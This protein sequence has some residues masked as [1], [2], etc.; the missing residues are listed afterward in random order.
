MQIAGCNALKQLL[1][2]DDKAENR[3][4]ARAAGAAAVLEAAAAAFAAETKQMENAKAALMEALA[5]AA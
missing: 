3:T 2:G 5:A 1:C 4:R